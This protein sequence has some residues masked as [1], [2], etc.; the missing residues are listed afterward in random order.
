M[1]AF[2]N[3]GDQNIYKDFQYVPQ[4][5]YRLG[6]TAPVQ[7]G[8]QDASTPSFG[9]PNT[10]AFTNSGAGFNSSLSND[11]YT[12][13]LNQGQF[14]TNRSNFGTGYIKGLEPEPS[15]FQPAIDLIGKGIGMAI[16]GGNFLMGLAK[17][18]SRENR[19][20]GTDNAFIDM[21]L[22]NQEQSMYGGNLTNQDRYGYNKDSLMGNYADKV[23]ERADIA[24]AKAK[25]NINNPDYKVRPIDAYYLE[26]EKEEEDVKNQ[27]NFNDFL[28]NKK[29]AVI[30]RRNIKTG[31]AI[32]PGAALHSELGSGRV[33]SSVIQ[34]EGGGNTPGTSRASDHGGV[35]LGHNAGNVRSAN[36]AGTGSKQSY[37]QNLRKG[38]RVGYFF[39]GRVNFKNGGL[40]SIL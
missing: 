23:R 15:K 32:D 17:N 8:G 7:G 33:T 31:T 10:N 35:G 18:Q 13:N 14:V 19:L 29:Q 9:I 38:G 1:V 37:N 25:E 27:T 28:N 24:R 22:A 11:P 36:A 40:A 39:G 16:P 30:A 34:G 21:Q 3:K 20:S 26:K 12:A 6:F 4:E 5:K 2:Y